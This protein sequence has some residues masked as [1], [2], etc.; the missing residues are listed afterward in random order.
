M[1]FCKERYFDHCFSQNELR[2]MQ[3]PSS[4]YS[5]WFRV[6]SSVLPQVQSVS[7]CMS[8]KTID[9]AFL[10]PL[11]TSPDRTHCPVWRCLRT[12]Q[13]DQSTV[14]TP[15][16]KYCSCTSHRRWNRSGDKILLTCIM[17]MRALAS[18]LVDTARRAVSTTNGG[19]S[20]TF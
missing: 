7:S 3:L 18:V 6:C 15:I 10:A 14:D 11:S 17:K 19:T 5:S 16:R 20:P 2:P 4:D 1:Q 13:R 12:D 8:P 9:T